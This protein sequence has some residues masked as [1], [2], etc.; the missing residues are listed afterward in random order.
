MKIETPEELID[1]LRPVIKEII[2]EEIKGLAPPTSAAHGYAVQE[3]LFSEAEC[4]ELAALMDTLLEAEAEAGTI[5]SD[6]VIDTK[7]RDSEVAWFNSYSDFFSGH[8]AHLAQSAFIR[9][10]GFGHVVRGSVLNG[11][12]PLAS[13]PKER[14]QVTRYRP[15][16]FYGDHRD[17]DSDDPMRRVLSMGVVLRHADQ[18]GRF[19][20]RDRTLPEEHEELIHRPGSAVA[21]PSSAYHQVTPVEEGE[22]LSLVL[23]MNGEASQSDGDARQPG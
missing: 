18:G 16:H 5:K 8:D 11:L 21:F 10:V 13:F 2:H 7:I 12:P 17:N 20:F 14:V 19:S 1:V 9:M 3:G 4:A 22:R 6:S 15:G 23:W